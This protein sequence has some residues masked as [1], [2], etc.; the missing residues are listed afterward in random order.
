[1]RMFC[2]LGRVVDLEIGDGLKRGR[3]G[4]IEI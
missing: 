3:E 2:G 1:M 4:K